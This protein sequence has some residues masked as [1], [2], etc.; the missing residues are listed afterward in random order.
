MRITEVI[1]GNRI[2][3]EI[4]PDEVESGTPTTEQPPLTTV[5]ELV[6]DSYQR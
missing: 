6:P 5:V 1:R 3:L 2:Y 4:L